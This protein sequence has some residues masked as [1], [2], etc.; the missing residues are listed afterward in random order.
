MKP[1]QST[2]NQRGV[3]ALEF[4][5]IA[6]LVF[7]LVYGLIEF[8][9]FFYDKAM[10]TNACREGARAGIVYVH[11]HNILEDGTDYD[12]TSRVEGA[13]NFFLGDYRGVNFSPWWG[14]SP[15]PK[16]ICFGSSTP[17]PG[18]PNVTIPT[19]TNKLRV[20]VSWNYDFLVLPHFGPLGW[21]SLANPFPLTAVSEMM[22]EENPA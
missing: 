17:N 3:S 5:I 2:Y 11:D 4:T 21:G 14:P 22:L 9:C 19:G 12:I 16:L 13:V 10:I 15:W 8:G 7:V 1:N 18:S 6:P 20:V